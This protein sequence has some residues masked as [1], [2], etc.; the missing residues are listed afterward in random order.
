MEKKVRIEGDY[1]YLPIQI[2]EEEKLIQINCLDTKN[3]AIKELEFMIPVGEIKQGVYPY[4]YFARFPVKQFTDKTIQLKGDVPEAFMD[5]VY[6]ASFIDYEPL[7]RPSIHFTPE[8]GWMNDP[9]GLVYKDGSYHLYFQYNPFNTSWNNMSWG[10]ATSRDLLHWRQEDSVLFPDED[11][12]IFSGSAIKNERKLLDI[13]KEALIF[14][15]TAAGG[16]NEWGKNKLF[17]Q[18]IAYSKNNGE[19]LIKL[20]KL[21]IDSITKE[22]R[23]PKVFWHEE[24]KAYIMS[25]WLEKNEFAI[26]RSTDLEHFVITDRLI[27]DDAWECPDLIRIPCE[28]GSSQW[29][30]WT[31]D[32]FYYF[33]SFDGY[34]FKTDKVRHKAYINGLPY[35]AQT[36]AGIKDRVV[37][38]SW[39]RANYEGQLYTGAMGL[40]RELSIVKKKGQPYLLQRPVKEFQKGKIRRECNIEMGVYQIDID[41][42]IEIKTILCDNAKKVCWNIGGT[43]VS[44]DCC[45]GRFEVD[46]ESYEVEKNCKNF[47]FIIDDTILE[48]TLN[49][50][51]MIG[52]FELAQTNPYIKAKA[53]D[54]QVWEVYAI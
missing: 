50:G 47:S 27:F 49:H 11:G 39:I 48:V 7:E 37:S 25:L 4:D 5:E 19:T 9:N 35:A 8:R 13:S 34:Q 12:M 22:N 21:K 51:I 2:G 46:N 36:Y 41:A 40:P 43:I 16:S 17:T 14:F 32:G 23:D 1:L 6:N 15:Y 38:I 54:F 52:V 44:Y 20:E 28:D 26:L 33:G 30:F 45:A 29:V 3:H 10:H 53:D 24:S 42:V 31:A 18:K